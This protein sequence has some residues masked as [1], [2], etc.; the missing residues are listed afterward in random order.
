MNK[1]GPI[2]A[3]SLGFELLECY[4]SF[5]FTKSDLN[6]NTIM[7]TGRLI[8]GSIVL[9]YT[10]WIW[11]KVKLLH[12]IYKWKFKKI[13]KNC[14]W[15]AVKYKLFKLNYVCLNSKYYALIYTFVN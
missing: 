1:Q 6:P 8:K 4:G 2:A 13:N 3:D 7:L 11:L 12:L 14:F 9:F 15:L 10:G 5:A